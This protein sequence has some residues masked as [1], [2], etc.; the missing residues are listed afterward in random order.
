MSDFKDLLQEAEKLTTDIEGATPLPKVDRSLKQVLE[1]SKEL[2]TRV[3]QTGGKDI[4]A[5]VLHFKS[6]GW[7]LMSF[8]Q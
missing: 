8:L 6:S 1:A 7:G 3:A 2:Y 4:Q 5:W